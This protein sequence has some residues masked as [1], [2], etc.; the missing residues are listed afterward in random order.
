[1]YATDRTK[2]RAFLCRS[3]ERKRSN[4]N[5]DTTVGG[6]IRRSSSPIGSEIGQSNLGVPAQTMRWGSLTNL[7]VPEAD[8]RRRSYSGPFG[9]QDSDPVQRR[10]SSTSSKLPQDKFGFNPLIQKLSNKCL[11]K[12]LFGMIAL[13][14]VVLLVS[15]YRLLT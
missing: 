7:S 3:R 15:I 4:Q 10:K 11:F 12:V 1:M 8:I 9:A 14:I 6:D 5:V 2:M 13:F